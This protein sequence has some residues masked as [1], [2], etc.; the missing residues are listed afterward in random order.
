MKPKL[1]AIVR[2][3]YPHKWKAI[4]DD[5]KHTSFGHQG[6]QDYTQHHDKQRRDLY[7]QRHAKDLQTKDP[8]RAGFLSYYILWGNSTSM[9]ENIKEY[10]RKYKM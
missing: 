3:T 8:R 2:G 5:G 4:F 7:R 10:K 6:Y 1:Q 9:A